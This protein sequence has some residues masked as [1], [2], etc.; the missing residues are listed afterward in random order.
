MLAA[1]LA[2]TATGNHRALRLSNHERT[3]QFGRSM[4]DAN[5]VDAPK[6]T[7]GKSWVN[8]SIPATTGTCGTGV[9]QL[10]WQDTQSG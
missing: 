7:V 3:T 2:G 10:R 6:K 1:W 9:T 8:R 5:S 4:V